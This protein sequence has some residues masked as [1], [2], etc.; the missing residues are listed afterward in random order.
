MELKQ[1]EYAECPKCENENIET[2]QNFCQ[3]CGYDLKNDKEP[4]RV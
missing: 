4:N 1:L 3:I 2:G